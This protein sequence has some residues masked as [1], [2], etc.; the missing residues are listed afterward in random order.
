MA[1]NGFVFRKKR[2]EGDGEHEDEVET[3]A[4]GGWMNRNDRAFGGWINGDQRAFGG[5]KNRN[6][7]S[8]GAWK[9]R[10]RRSFGAWKNR[11]RRGFNGWV[12]KKRD[13]DDWDNEHFD[14]QDK[15]DFYDLG[16][17]D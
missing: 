3:R 11:N 14:F 5:W 1:S 4:F 6:K 12:D 17:G 8:F 10:N 13:M 7:R 2:S 16:E 9:N 15:R